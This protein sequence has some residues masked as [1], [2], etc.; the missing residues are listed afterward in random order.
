MRDEIMKKSILRVGKTLLLSM[1]WLANLSSNILFGTLKSGLDQNLSK[2][3]ENMNIKMDQNQQPHVFKRVLANGMTVLVRPVHA[4]PKVTLQIWYNV[5]SKDEKTSEKG[6]AHLIE[7]MFFKGTKQ[8]SESDINVIT[9]MLSGSTNAFTS[10]DYTG[11]LFNMPVQNWH[12]ALALFAD[13]MQNVSFKDDHLNSEMKAVIQELKMG[14]DNYARSLMLE[15]FSAIFPDHPYHY[16]VIGFKQDLF[17]VHADR[18]RAFYKKHYWPN[19]A[20]LVIVGDV[21]PE[22]AFAQAK[23]YFEK[24]PANKDYKKEEFYFNKDI[25]SHN[26]TL[27]RDVQQPFAVMGYVVP[28]LQTKNEHLFDVINMV[29]GSGKG[30][31]LYRK[32]VDEL[33]LV[34]DLGSAPWLLFEHGLFMIMFEPKNVAD[35]P[36]IHEIVQ[37]EIDDIV[38]NG[39]TDQEYTRAL[40]QSLRS[41]YN[42][43]ESIETQAREIGKAYLSTGDENFAFQFLNEPKEEV[44]KQIQEILRTY[45][46]PSLMHTGLLLPLSEQDKKE[47][48]AMQKKSDEYDTKFLAARPRTSPIEAPSFANKVKVNEATRFDFPKYQTMMLSNGIKVLYYCND[49]TP[50]IDLIFELK[51]RSY[52]DSQELPGIYNFVS[53]L[54]LEGTKN[55]TAKQLT[56]ELEMRGMNVSVAPGVIMMNLLAS[57]LQK[58][59]ELLEEIVARPRFDDEEIEKVREQLLSSIKFFWDNP[60]SF[61]KQLVEEH[62]YKGHPFAKNTLGT[63]ESISKITKNDLIAFHKKYFSPDGARLAIVGDI[64][65]YDLKPLLEKTIG[66]FKGPKVESIA[67]PALEPIKS[68]EKI[69]PINRDQVVLCFAGLSVDRKN[70]D[71][72]KLLLFDQTFGGG[73]LGSLHSKLYQL[74][75]QSGL[76]YN[77]SG[78]LVSGATEQ[79]GMVKVTTIVSLDRL[80][81][82]EKAIKKVIDEAVDQVTDREFLEAKRAIINAVVDN[83]ASNANMANVFLSMDRYGF[84]ADYYDTRAEKLSAI[85]IDQMKEAAKKVLR[86]EAMFTLKVGRLE[87]KKKL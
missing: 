25:I 52:Y 77:I 23:K 86:N 16:P 5:G 64:G 60:R 49:N 84:P 63:E 61:A 28:G 15:M 43:L 79:P 65:S 87:E 81:E 13:C 71:Y 70:P 85:T 69:H 33:H 50:K 75:E 53:S 14:R 39:L 30:S 31:R 10:H 80:A 41:Y 66:Q 76:F 36:L 12:Q 72:D 83:F 44:E 22:D 7:H 56:D 21:D 68:C 42:L 67:F 4:L 2:N 11:Y 45:F 46:K 51:A 3:Q 26:V 59:L 73:V 32:L 78:S 40:K 82:A 58:G 37:K 8:L 54:L 55:Y 47:W 34:T 35:I 19:N 20:T 27:Y 6:I 57:D 29:L 18:L 48:A 17:D 1:I 62:V 74:R 24:I 9:Q 38:Q